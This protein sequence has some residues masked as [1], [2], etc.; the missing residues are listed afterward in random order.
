VTRALVAKEVRKDFGGVRALQGVSLAVQ[1]GE[2]L[3]LIGPNG[4]GKTTLLSI[5]SG[6]LR[7]SSGTILLDDRRIDGLAEHRVAELGVVKT[8]Q[9]PKPFLSM[10]VRENVAVAAMFGSRKLR[11]LREANE[12]ADRVLSLVGM[13]AWSDALAGSLPVQ[14]RKHLEL[15]RALATGA[16]ILLLD[17]VFAGQSPEDL[18][19]SMDLF[20]RVQAELG[21]G[22][23]V[24]EHVMR[25]VL[26]LTHR[27]VVIEEGRKIAEGAPEEITRDPLVIEAYLGQG[28]VRAPP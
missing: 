2:V 5:L 28:A 18:K 11:E 22:A 19:R 9:I 15:A 12:V 8:H 6:S 10:T 1:E 23:L 17:E 13:Q 25:A 27:V 3:G 7:P 24:V 4:S 21:F 20:A 14:S 16:R 26:T